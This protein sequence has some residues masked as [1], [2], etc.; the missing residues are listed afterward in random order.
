[1]RAL[2]IPV[3]LLMEMIME[4][5]PLQLLLMEMLLELLVVWS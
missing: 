4:L 1:M 2:G 3:Q 5:P